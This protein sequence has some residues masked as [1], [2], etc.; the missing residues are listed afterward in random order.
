MHYFFHSDECWENNNDSEDYIIVEAPDQL[1]QQETLPEGYN[2]AESLVKWLTIIFLRLQGRHYVPDS[3]MNNLFKFI[4]R[5][6]KLPVST[7]LSI[8]CSVHYFQHH[9]LLQERSMV[10]SSP[11]KF[12]HTLCVLVQSAL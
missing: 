7:H 8:Y 1:V 3:A 5:F 12:C 11:T 6:L 10:V 2:E 4:S 9:Y